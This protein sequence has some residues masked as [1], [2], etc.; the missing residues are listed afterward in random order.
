VEFWV[1]MKVGIFA[2]HVLLSQRLDH[3]EMQVIHS[4]QDVR[5]CEIF[6]IVP[7]LNIFVLLVS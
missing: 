2:S 5:V 7:T 1:G 4:D 6:H 3:K